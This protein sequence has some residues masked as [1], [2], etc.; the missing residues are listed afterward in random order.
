M[1]ADATLRKSDPVS[2]DAFD[3]PPVFLEQ[4]RIDHGP[5]N[6]IG[7]FFL[8]A[9]MVVRSAGIRL[10]FAPLRATAALQSEN[11][12]S[13]SVFP[14]MLDCRLS[15]IPDEDS[16]ALVGRDASGEIACCQGGRIYRTGERTLFDII[17]DQS[18]FYG[19]ECGELSGKPTC[20]VTA[21]S[22]HDVKG[23]F[24]YSGALWVRPDFRGHK[25]GA[26]LPRISRAYALSKWNTDFT[27]ALVSDQIANSPLLAMYGYRNVDHG[28]RMHGV[29]PDVITGCV[30]TMDRPTLLTDLELNLASLRAQIDTAVSASS[31][32][33]QP[34]PVA[35]RDRNRQ[36]RIA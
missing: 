2:H 21:Q 14:P 36:S 1:T 6:L 27:I 19:T 11:K 16:Y 3:V 22:T 26:I 25:L 12:K 8:A 24:V 33:D 34:Q 5:A 9:E 10:S 15:Q 20:E 23:C 18:F 28:F 13:W 17:T 7:Q 29:L 35:E 31:A 4:I 30:L 32:E